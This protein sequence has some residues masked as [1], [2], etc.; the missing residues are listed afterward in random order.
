[1]DRE[2][3]MI[4]VLRGE[5]LGYKFGSSI[6]VLVGVLA[7]YLNSFSRFSAEL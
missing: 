2:S 1:M 3:L 6:F 5:E 4:T 7:K